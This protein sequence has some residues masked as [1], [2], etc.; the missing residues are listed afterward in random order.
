MENLRIRPG[1]IHSYIQAAQEFLVWTK[2]EDITTKD[3]FT[4]GVAFIEYLDHLFVAGH[5]KVKAAAAYAGIKQLAVAL[6]D[7]ISLINRL[8]DAFVA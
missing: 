3:L 7:Y 5:R 2:E 8:C 6:A 1:T 4:T